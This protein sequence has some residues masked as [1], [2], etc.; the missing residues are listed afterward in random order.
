MNDHDKMSD[1]RVILKFI[2]KK[3]IIDNMEVIL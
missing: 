3:K 1:S 2:E